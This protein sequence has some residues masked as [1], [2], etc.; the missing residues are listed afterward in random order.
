M[1]CFNL[2]WLHLPTTSVTCFASLFYLA[3]NGP[4]IFGSAWHGVWLW[5]SWIPNQRSLPSRTQKLPRLYLQT[6]S[7]CRYNWY[8]PFASPHL[9]R[10]SRWGLPWRHLS[11]DCQEL[12]SF[13]CWCLPAFDRQASAW[14]GQSTRQIRLQFFHNRHTHNLLLLHHMLI[15]SCA[16]TAGSF[17][18]CVLPESIKVSA[19][20]DVNAHPD[21]SGTAPASLFIRTLTWLRWNST[22]Q[23]LCHLIKVCSSPNLLLLWTALHKRLCSV[24]WGWHELSLIYLYLVISIVT[25]WNCEQIVLLFPYLVEDDEPSYQHKI[26]RKLF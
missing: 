5:S 26:A 14:V 17:F 4:Y 19:V 21:F 10:G 25:T 13:Y 3:T 22:L 9:H 24:K 15:L 23:N 11:S 8:V 6:L 1:A 7:L 20:R 18:N 2:P 16:G 12:Q